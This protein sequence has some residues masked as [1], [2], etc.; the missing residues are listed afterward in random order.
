MQGHIPAD[1]HPLDFANVSILHFERAAVDWLTAET[2]YDE[3]ASRGRQFIGI[4]GN[5]P[6]WVESRL[7]ALAQLVRRNRLRLPAL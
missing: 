1:P 5:G 4:G 2:R 7:E 3:D 6:C